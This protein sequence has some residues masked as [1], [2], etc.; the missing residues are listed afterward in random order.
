MYIGLS[1]NIYINIFFKLISSGIYVI[2]R[3]DY[4]CSICKYYKF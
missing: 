3:N 2:E 1:P 4:C